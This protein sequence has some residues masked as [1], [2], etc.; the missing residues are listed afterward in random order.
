MIKGYKTM[1][2]PTKEQANKIIKFC[3]ASRYI[4]N[5]ALSL[6]EEAYKN[7]DKFITPYNLTKELTKFKKQPDNEWLKEISGRALKVSVM[8]LGKSYERFFKG[9]SKHPKYKSKKHSKM[10]CATHE[11]TIIIE[12][13]KIRCEKLGWIKSHKHNIPMGKNIKYYNPRLS[14]DG[15]NFWFSVGAEILDDSPTPNNNKTE[16]IGIDLG[17]KTLATCSNGMNWYKVDISK[18]KKRL[19]R[20]QKKASRYY[21]RMVL[22]SKETKTKFQD[23]KK[24]KNLLKLEAKIRKLYRK[25]NNKLNNNIHNFTS[26][27]IK[28]NPKS[29]VIEDLNVSGMLK[30]KHLSEKIKEAKF[31]EIRRQ[32]EYKCKWNNIELIIADRFYPSSKICS[33]CGN[34]KTKLSLSERTYVCEECGAII[35][36]DFNASLN[37]KHLTM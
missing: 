37:L 33:C 28:L 24:S 29:I 17:I 5:W 1:I 26:V 25:I 12:K 34:K 7:G 2:Y 16:P 31:Y 23:I 21:Q 6:E 32:L 35:D 19:K 18:E 13:K 15:D 9:L 20:L 4:Y 8:T 36:R 30:N 27:L 3:N 11:G 10:S 14:F 22:L